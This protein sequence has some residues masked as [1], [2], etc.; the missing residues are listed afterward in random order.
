[1]VR[2]IVIAYSFALVLLIPVL[3]A[4]PAF[5]VDRTEQ[6][7]NVLNE[8][9]NTSEDFTSAS[10]LDGPTHPMYL[11]LRVVFIVFYLTA[12]IMFLLFFYAGGLWLTARGNSDQVGKS[13]KIMFDA[14]VGFFVLLISYTMF[15][16]II[17]TVAAPQDFENFRQCS[18][19]SSV[20]YHNPWAC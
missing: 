13:K 9:K 7:N 16:L 15:V 20:D 11:I 17:S 8:L 6:A 4:Q 14:V 10:Q 1:M 5:A 18:P 19:R 12:L 3:V 2:R